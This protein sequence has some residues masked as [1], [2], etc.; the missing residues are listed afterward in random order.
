MINKGTILF[1]NDGV[2]ENNGTFENRGSF[3]NGGPN[4]TAVFNNNESGS[5][6]GRTGSVLVN[7]GNFNNKGYLLIETNS[8]FTIISNL[9]TREK[10]TILAHSKT[11][12]ALNLSM[13]RDYYVGGDFGI[14]EP[15]SY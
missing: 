11:L 6:L 15:F 3:D 2:F 12:N 7:T 1:D 13:I 4:S 14:L 9:P 5:F 8:L 10:S